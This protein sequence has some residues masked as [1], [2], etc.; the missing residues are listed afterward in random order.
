MYTV[1]DSHN[2]WVPRPAL[3]IEHGPCGVV[4]QADRFRRACSSFISPFMCTVFS[5]LLLERA[6]C[7]SDFIQSRTLH[8]HKYSTKCSFMFLWLVP[9]NNTAVR[10]KS[11]SFCLP[12]RQG[13]P[14]LLDTLRL[15]DHFS[16]RNLKADIAKRR[17][18]WDHLLTS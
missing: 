15:T 4:K 8:L 11:S 14:C 2:A 12:S 9:T 13:P 10:C 1:P 5:A 16:P 6:T 3:S 18:A 7:H 17:C